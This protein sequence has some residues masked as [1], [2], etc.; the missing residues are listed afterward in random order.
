MAASH[1][2]MERIAVDPGVSV[3]EPIAAGVY[4][5]TATR[6]LPIDDR[7]RVAYCER[8]T[9]RTRA[10][11]HV[12]IADTVAAAL[13]LVFAIVVDRAVRPVPATA[14]WIEVSLGL[15]M[16]TILI[17]ALTAAR[18]YVARAIERP[19]EPIRRRLPVV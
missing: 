16:I 4:D 10:Q 8:V 12:R 18:C 14:L 13:G 2:Q 1:V 15:I 3:P 9:L 6:A 17:G 7:A 19:A 11:I 5:G